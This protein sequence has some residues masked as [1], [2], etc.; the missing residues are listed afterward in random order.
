MAGNPTLG[1]VAGGMSDQTLDQQNIQLN[2]QAMQANAVTLQRDQIGL[3]NDKIALQQNLAMMQAMAGLKPGQG[4]DTPEG[5]ADIMNQVAGI[6]LRSGKINDAVKTAGEA[7]KLTENASKIDYRGYRMQN[8]RFNKFANLLSTVPDTQEGYQQ[9]I[10]TMMSTDPRVANDKK[11]QQLAQTPW[12]PGL[13]P[14]LRT[15]VMSAKDAA[16]V[17]YRTAATKKEVVDTKL[18][19]TRVDLVHAQTRLADAKA[20]GQA[21]V[22]VI[23]YK[24][25]QLRSITDQALRDYP[26]ADPKDINVRSRSLAEETAKLMV[27]DRL[28]L[29]EASTRVYENAKSSG[30]F[31]GLRSMPVQKG[32]RPENALPLPPM[33]KNGKAPVLQENQWYDVKGTPMLKL[34]DQM[35]THDELNSYSK[36]EQE[37][38]GVDTVDD[39]EDEK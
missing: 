10:Q 16:E 25:E 39:D 36:D 12:R 29:S 20:A 18:D 27:S 23:P 37:A 3:T 35:Y 5:M 38:L 14:A 1:S 11:F 33:G 4:G 6:Q 24:P 34:G 7:S 8:D 22:G 13:V 31:A 26:A 19:A 2:T 21:K 32:T 15:Q 17:A 9:A 30:K 28:T